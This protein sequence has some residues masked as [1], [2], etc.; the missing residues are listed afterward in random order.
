MGLRLWRRSRDAVQTFRHR[1]ELDMNGEKLLRKL[2]HKDL[3]HLLQTFDGTQTLEEVAEEAAQTLP[4]EGVAAGAAPD[5][6]GVKTVGR[7]QRLELIDPLADALIFGDANLSFALKL[8]RHRKGL[9]HV[10]R[11]I[12]TTFENI[13]TLR[14]RYKEIDETIKSLEDLYAEVW[15]GVDCTRIAV[16]PKFEG[17]ENTF[18]AVYYNFPH[19][20]AV[21]GFFDGHPLVN[22]RHENLM[23][24]LFRALRSF[25]KPGGSVK[26]ASNS[27][28]VGVRYSYII[29]GA[30]QNEF[31]H[32][33][34]IPFLDWSLRR[35]M[36]SYGD[37]RDVYKRPEDGQV[38]NVPPAAREKLAGELFARFKAEVTGTHIG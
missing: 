8:A 5:W 6:P 28:A 25:V 17:L 15:H 24:L 22:W 33:E 35:Y 14:E 26:V 10:G 34:T 16:D 1:W 7:F 31:V 29:D 2:N 18:G 32:V 9:G 21:R 23:R 13:E 20:G 4:Q 38:Y 12:A 11:V 27:S 37:R 30:A 3:R 36:R 19:A